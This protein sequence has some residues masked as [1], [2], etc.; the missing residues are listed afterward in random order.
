MAPQQI[1]GELF[2]IIIEIQIGRVM[3]ENV[4]VRSASR[5]PGVQSSPISFGKTMG[6]SPHGIQ[7]I[8]SAEHLIDVGS[9]NI[10]PTSSQIPHTNAGSTTSLIAVNRYAFLS[11][12]RSLSEKDERVS[13]VRIMLN[14]PTQEAEV[15]RIFVP[16]SG[17]LKPVSPTIIPRNIEMIMGL[18]ILLRDFP[19][20][21]NIE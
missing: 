20:P 19:F 14:G 1:V 13:P 3:Q 18:M 7:D 16:I 21:V 15:V 8:K 17:I 6:L 2:Y 9:G 11:A 4:C 10:N 12:A 5:A